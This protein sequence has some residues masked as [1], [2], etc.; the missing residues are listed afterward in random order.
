MNSKGHIHIFCKKEGP[1]TFMNAHTW[2]TNYSYLKA[3]QIASFICLCFIHLAVHISKWLV[4]DPIV[5]SYVFY[6]PV[7]KRSIDCLSMHSS[8]IPHAQ[9]IRLIQEEEMI[10]VSNQPLKFF[11]CLWF[12]YSTHFSPLRMVSFQYIYIKKSVCK[13]KIK[14]K[15]S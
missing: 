3:L 11:S 2:I 15:L 9:G 7:I 5:D 13:M 12:V 6:M 4:D 8:C 14:M 10:H 1:P